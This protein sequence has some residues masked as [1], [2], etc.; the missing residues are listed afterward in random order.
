MDLDIVQ[1]PVLFDLR[2]P[3]TIWIIPSIV[4]SQLQLDILHR[5]KVMVLHMIHSGKWEQTRAWVFLATSTLSFSATTERALYFITSCFKAIV[6][7]IPV[8][9]GRKPFLSISRI[10]WE[11]VKR[12]A[13]E[14][15]FSLILLTQ[16]YRPKISRFSSSSY[17]G[18]TTKHERE[19]RLR[20][21]F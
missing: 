21:L 11:P 4:S 17:V 2:W 9:S 20:C 13:G 5:N 10:A 3:L 16:Q 18:S 7:A 6:D 1:S 14:A 12:Q 15:I 8:Q 19:L